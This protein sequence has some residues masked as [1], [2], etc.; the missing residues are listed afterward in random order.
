MTLHRRPCDP[1]TCPI[2]FPS[3]VRL[4]VRDIGRGTWAGDAALIATLTL[5]AVLAA[6]L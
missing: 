1:Q 5:C 2:C 6:C 4:D 3:V